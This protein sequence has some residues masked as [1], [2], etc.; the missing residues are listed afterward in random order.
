MVQ[1]FTI[2]IDNKH[3]GGVQKMEVHADIREG[4]PFKVFLTRIGQQSN[5]EY[6]TVHYLLKMST[7]NDIVFRVDITPEGVAEKS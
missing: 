5:V 1:D 4:F 7:I 3:V 6:T 2:F